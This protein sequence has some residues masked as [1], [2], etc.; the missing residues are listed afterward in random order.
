MQLSVLESL[1]AHSL[2]PNLK[3]LRYKSTNP[4][5][6]LITSLNI[7]ILLFHT[8]GIFFVNFISSKIYFKLGLGSPP[9]KLILLEPF[10]ILINSF[11]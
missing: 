1:D 4:S 2:L 11:S 7:Y 5:N 6:K 8:T 3:S 9:K 10:S